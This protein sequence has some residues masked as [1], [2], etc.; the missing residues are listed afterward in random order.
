MPH[1]FSDYPV[2]PQPQP[3]SADGRKPPGQLATIGEFVPP[4]PPSRQPNPAHVPPNMQRRLAIALLIVTVAALVIFGRL[5]KVAL[6][7]AFP[8]P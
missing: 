5:G 4:E 8:A 7:P 2:E 1:S 6:A 3:A